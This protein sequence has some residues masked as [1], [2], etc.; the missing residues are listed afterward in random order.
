MMGS[1][2]FGDYFKG[3]AIELAFELITGEFGIPVERLS[4]TVFTAAQTVLRTVPS[5]AECAHPQFGWAGLFT[6]KL[7]AINPGLW[8]NPAK[9][10]SV[11]LRRRESNEAGL[12]SRRGFVVVRLD[13][14]RQ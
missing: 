11:L 6:N 10:F 12:D 13:G 5:S 14:H 3:Q 8:H 7:M 4:A 9:Q 2:S 1:W